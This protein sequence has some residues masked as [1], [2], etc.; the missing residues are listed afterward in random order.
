MQLVQGISLARLLR[1]LAEHDAALEPEL[2]AWI[3]A[4]ASLGLHAAHELEDAAGRPVGLVHRDVSPENVLL[5]W[6]G[7]VYVADFGVAKLADQ[8]RATKSGVV[9]GKFAYMSPEQ[10]RA[11]ALDRRSDVFSLGVLLHES[12]TGRRLFAGDSPADTIRRIVEVEPVDPATLRPDVPA[13]ISE[14][15]LRCLS[16]KPGDRPASAAEVADALRRALRD[17]RAMVDESD[18]A[19]LLD[20]YFADERRRL[21]DRLRA[22]AGD[23]AAHGTPRGAPEGASEEGGAAV[24]VAGR[25]SEHGSVTAAIG[26]APVRSRRIAST[27]AVLGLACA[28]GVG[29]WVL[30]SRT[31]PSP[32][33]ADAASAPAPP[34]SASPGE[35][36][37]Q[38]TAAAVSATAAPAASASVAQTPAPPP[39]EI[40]RVVAPRPSAKPSLPAA[41]P[42]PA[43]PAPAPS[44][45]GVPF[46]DL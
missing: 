15:A 13:A 44:H 39:V 40:R 2:A 38:S 8:D 23:E 9:K 37:A 25:S 5:S 12:L 1:R 7:R 4:Q 11:G 30:A 43:A 29:W 21:R 33:A 24:S 27:T 22:A 46:R 36:Q 6:E 10:T 42:P 34:P 19:A 20:R 26:S 28:L 32:V 31:S 41:P 18:V 35:A 14:V 17:G 3:C 45:G 16:K